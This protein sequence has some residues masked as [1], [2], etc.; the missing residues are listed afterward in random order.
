VSRNA[1]VVANSRYLRRPRVFR[2]WCDQTVNEVVVKSDFSNGIYTIHRS[3]E[4][5]IDEDPS[6]FTNFNGSAI[7]GKIVTGFDAY[8]RERQ[9]GEDKGMVPKKADSK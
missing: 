7:T 2:T 6:A 3:L 5:F 1:I 4:L 9:R 8:E